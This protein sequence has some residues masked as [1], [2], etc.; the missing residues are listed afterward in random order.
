MT[1]TRFR[2]IAAV[3]IATL[4]SASPTHA[5][6][7]VLRGGGQI[8]GKII[9]GD[10]KR[11]TRVFVLT[12]RGKTPLTFEKT[13][14]AEVIPETGPLDG[15]LSR[16]EK[17]SA[18]DAKAQYDLGVYCEENKLTDL[19]LMHYEAA[20]KAD[21]KFAPAHEK[22]RHVLHGDRWL[23]GDEIKEAQGLVKYKGKWVTVGVRDQQ[24]KQVATTAEQASWVRRL[25]LLR[26]ALL[27]GIDDRRREAD[28][29]L[30]SI[31]EPIAIKPLIKVF[32]SDPPAVRS[33][34]ARFLGA[35]DGP[36]ASAALVSRFLYED[37][38]EVRL[39][40]VD[41][42][43]RRADAEVTKRLV[44]GLRSDEPDIVNRA[45]WALAK[46]NAVKTV[47]MLVNV[48][49][50]TK[51]VIE[52]ID[53]GQAGA[54]GGSSV[55]PNPGGLPPPGLGRTPGHMGGSTAGLNGMVQYPTYAAA[56]PGGVAALVPQ[57]GSYSTGAALDGSGSAGLSGAGSGMISSSSGLSNGG[58]VPSLGSGRMPSMVFY[59]F[60]NGEVLGALIKMTGQDFGYDVD[61]WKR[62]IRTSFRPD[63]T[64]ARH[65]PQP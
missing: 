19:A 4:V 23:T 32:G 59:T 38:S 62:W 10:P 65:V 56:G 1:R 18:T 44:I 5:D 25:R 11:P 3:V 12:E 30:M 15:Y 47:P 39:S 61:A 13:L 17:A 42:L 33:M 52:A 43:L 58:G 31:N 49:V 9:P 21:D 57:V 64:P 35:I 45:A 36:E 20:L 8:K 48:L 6:K 55:S 28:A 26:D 7:I 41:E 53:S 27:S 34:L 40:F 54:M 50:Q 14:I 2:A 46:L 51:T 16:R 22:L 60:R 24:E 63:S 29:Q 37:E